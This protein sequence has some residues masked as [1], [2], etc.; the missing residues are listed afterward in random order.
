[1]PNSIFSQS[2]IILGNLKAPKLDLVHC[3]CICVKVEFQLYFN[4]KYL[5]MMFL[6][7]NLMLP[8]KRI[9][10]IG[11]SMR[12]SSKGPTGWADIYFEILVNSTQLGNIS[13]L[14]KCRKLKAIC[15]FPHFLI[16]PPP[17]P[18]YS[19]CLQYWFRSSEF[20]SC[21]PACTVFILFFISARQ[22]WDLHYLVANRSWQPVAQLSCHAWWDGC[23]QPASYSY[24]PCS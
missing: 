20:V 22:L 2:Y 19:R 24:I 15:T 5:E 3:V 14:W 23:A 12:I 6:H 8:S 4:T 7:T 11:F 13:T 18:M 17:I 16:P 21:T 9:L 10:L 1:M